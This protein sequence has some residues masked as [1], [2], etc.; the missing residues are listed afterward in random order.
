[1]AGRWGWT[2]SELA[3]GSSPGNSIVACPRRPQN[4]PATTQ[5]HLASA[6]PSTPDH[7]DLRLSEIVSRH[8]SNKPCEDRRRQG[9]KE[10]DIST[11]PPTGRLRPRDQCY[12]RPRLGIAWTTA[13][14]PNL[15][16]CLHRH[17]PDSRNPR[18]AHLP[19]IIASWLAP[20]C[21]VDPLLHVLLHHHQV[22]CHP[23]G[24]PRPWID[25]NG[26]CRPR[27]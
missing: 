15:C 7:L 25:S 11:K 21:P 20:R 6:L 4:Q 23:H 12:R 8:T 3:H 24:C 1:M 18:N 14:S 5:S 9:G 2:R 19:P 16:V 17:P 10:P 27:L 26:G 22:W 13:C